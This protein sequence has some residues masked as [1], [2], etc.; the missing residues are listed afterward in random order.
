M[1]KGSL[2]AV[3][4]WFEL[5]FGAKG[6]E[7]R[8]HTYSTSPIGGGGGCWEQA[9]FPVLTPMDVK[10]GDEFEVHI[11]V[12]GKNVFFLKD[13]R[14]VPAPAGETST[15]GKRRRT[16]DEGEEEKEDRERELL[17]LPSDILVA[18]NDAVLTHAYA[19][20][21]KVVRLGL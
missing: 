6:D 16:G 2:S 7:T 13:F 5:D 17:R 1:L 15:P 10:I 14:K 9:I 8:E 18:L 19:E 4:L 3:A 21:A 12:E 11:A 20:C